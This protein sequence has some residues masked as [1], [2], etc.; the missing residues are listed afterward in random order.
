MFGGQGPLPNSN[1]SVS[2]TA[3]QLAAVYTGAVDWATRLRASR[4]SV[5]S[6]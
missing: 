2:R 6:P 5:G 1:L 3:G 4:I